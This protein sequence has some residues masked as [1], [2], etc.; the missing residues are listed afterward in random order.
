ALLRGERG[1]LLP[2]RAV[3]WATDTP[4]VLRVD[5]PGAVATAVAPGSARLT[6]TCEGIRA[7]L[8]VQVAPP[9]V[10]DAD[11]QPVARVTA[12]Q[13]SAPAKSVKAGDSFGLTAT[14]LDYRDV[15][16]LGYPGL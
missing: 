13:I 8:Q 9:I 12:I 10:D 16:L 14:P 1:T 6:A 3:Q 2:G 15:F 5:G 11:V 7:R 4:E